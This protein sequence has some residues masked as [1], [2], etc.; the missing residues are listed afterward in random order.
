MI[1]DARVSHSRASI[2]ELFARIGEYV[3]CAAMHIYARAR[4]RVC[5]GA[6]VENKCLVCVFLC[7][8][9]RISDLEKGPLRGDSVVARC[10]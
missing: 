9:F 3:K 6:K 2:R 5:I 10:D 1:L 8:V 7:P 4:A